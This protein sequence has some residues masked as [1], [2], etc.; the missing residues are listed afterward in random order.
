MTR[1]SNLLL[2]AFLAVLVGVITVV[3]AGALEDSPRVPLSFNERVAAVEHIEDVYWAH[4]IWPEANPGSKPRRDELTSHEQIVAKVERSLLLEGVL[5][6]VFGEHLTDRRIQ[7]ELNRIVKNTRHPVLLNDV[8]AAL[9]HDPVLIAECYVRPRLVERLVHERFAWDQSIHADLRGLALAE[10]AGSRHVGDLAGSSAEISESTWMVTRASAVGEPPQSGVIELSPDEWPTHT[11]KLAGRFRKDTPGG[12]DAPVP[13]DPG[14]L[15]ARQA[16]QGVSPLFETAGGFAVVEILE[17]TDGRLVVAT[18]TWAKMAFADWLQ[19]IENELVPAMPP[20][21]SYTLPKLASGDPCIDD[22]WMPTAGSGPPPAASNLEAVWTGSEMVVWGGYDGSAAIDTGGRYDPAAD[23]WLPISTSDAPSVRYAHTTVW[24]GTKVIVWGGYDGSSAIDTG[25]RYDPVTDSWAPVETTGAPSA[26]W[27][28]LA[29]WTGSTMIVWGGY[30]GSVY[31][32]TGGAYDPV[33]D[34]WTAT[35]T[36]GAPSPRYLCAVVWSGSEMIVWGGYDGSQTYNDGGRYDPVA[37]SWTATATTGAPIGRYYN[38]GVWTGSEMIVWGGH[39]GSTPLNDGGRYDPLADS[40]TSVSTSGA[41]SMRYTFA[42]VWSGTEMIVWGGYSGSTLLNDGGRYDPTSDSWTATSSSGAP[43]ARRTHTAVWTGSEMIV[44]GGASGS[45]IFNDGG[46]YDPTTDSWMA[47]SMGSAPT[48]RQVHSAVW[49]GAEMI[50]WGGYDG[51]NTNTGSRYDAAA[52]TWLATTTDGAPSGRHNHTAVWT[53]AE[54]VVW[55]GWAGSPN[56]FN[57]GGRYDPVT[58][59]WT[60]TTTTGAPAARER[61][62]GVWTGAEMIVWGG[63]NGSSQLN[64]G[65]R[66]DPVADSWAATTTSGAPSSRFIHTAVWAEDEMIVWGGTAG[67]PVNT[68]G[69]YDPVA[70]SWTAT[71]TGGAPSSR[72]YHS[73]VWTGA[74]MIVW[75]GWNGT[76]LYDT[77]GRYD[78]TSNSWQAMSTADA[79]TARLVPG[80]VW[81]GSEVVTWGGTDAI[82][83]FTSGGRYDPIADSWSP[84]ALGFAP[85]PARNSPALWTGTEM[86]VWGGW[87]SSRDLLRDTGGRYCAS[88][89]LGIDY[90]DVPDPTYPTLSFSDGARHAS[91]GV[92]FLGASVDYETDGQPTA[93]ADGDDLDGTDDEDGVVFTSALR[94]GLDATLD[95]T[96][97]A[98]GVLNAWIDLNADGD[99]ADAGEQV[100]TDTALVAGVNNLQV[101]VPLSATLGTTFA[102]F[103]LDSTGGLM[104]TGLAGDGEVEDYAV[105]VEP[106]AELGV[107]IVDEPDP[108][109]QGTTLTYVVKVANGGG[110]DATGVVLTDTLDGNTSFVSASLPACSHNAGV[111]T[112]DLGSVVGGGSAEVEIEV[113]VAGGFTGLLTNGASVVLNEGDPVP[114]NNSDSETTEVVAPGDLVFADDFEIGTADNWSSTVGG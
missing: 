29:V 96:A 44:W 111:V 38:L 4:R 3:D 39:S 42:L 12:P 114:A 69:R 18:A 23:S 95:V 22:T 90:G 32:D 14:E 93:G 91:Y 7:V 81:T 80:M 85:P 103:R 83:S 53:G 55:G 64:T 104:P 92:L 40:W 47:T 65:G 105:T 66:Y 109:I 58:D 1:G 35:S 112:C 54:M 108:V 37:D 74:E 106:S 6:Q 77:G 41:P 36:T 45:T 67:S 33:T 61:H 72:Y 30:D 28:Q 34:S 78:P 99:W 84:T 31:F 110:L 50:V 48:R 60:A 63:F 82:V 49:T 79:P 59:S 19:G 15:L 98:T 68:G 70:D 76:T 71:S 113:T 51:S 5:E 101:A 56:Y 73:A 10:L 20:A 25:G 52:D 88:G 94:L 21:G 102:R 87:D 57:T 2:S 100:F 27:G 11:R 43:S 62:T 75:A 26:R 16:G 46:R 89:V 13:F 107:T 24:T 8:F 86:I 9:D 97:S 17:A